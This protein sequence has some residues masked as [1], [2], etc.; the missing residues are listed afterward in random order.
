MQAK[1][2]VMKKMIFS[3]VVVAMVAVAGVNVYKVSA[4][5]VEMSDLQKENVEAL[6]TWEGSM[7]LDIN[8]RWDETAKD[9]TR[10]GEE[11]ICLVVTCS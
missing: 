1:R 5:E 8:C 11:S 6:A 10:V 2:E 3:L 9:C 7:K 4:S